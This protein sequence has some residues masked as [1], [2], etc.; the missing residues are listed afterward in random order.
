MRCPNR[1]RGASRQDLSPLSAE[2]YFSQAL[3]VDVPISDVYPSTST[4][5][6]ST[7][8]FRVYYTAPSGLNEDE[9]EDDED[10]ASSKGV[11]FVCVHG[12]GYSGLS[13][14]CAAK[15]LVEKGKGKV[16]VLSFDARGHGEFNLYCLS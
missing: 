6:P 2:G 3:Q 12:A 4:G 8:S 10:G 15:S 9:E 7:A 1:R 5:T 11:V 16:G 13:Y 14:A